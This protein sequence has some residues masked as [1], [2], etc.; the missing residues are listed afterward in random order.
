MSTSVTFSET[1]PLTM[2]IVTDQHVSRVEG[3]VNVGTDTQPYDD[4]FATNPVV[5]T[6][7][8]GHA[9]NLISD[10]KGVPTSTIIYGY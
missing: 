6:D 10:D 2:T 4:T 8:T 1:L 3:T 9:W 7:T 5:I